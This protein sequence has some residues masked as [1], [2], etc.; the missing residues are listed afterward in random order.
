LRLSGCGA[1]NEQTQYRYIYC[2]EQSGKRLHI[3][4]LLIQFLQISLALDLPE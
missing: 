2:S 1:E 3:L 4:L